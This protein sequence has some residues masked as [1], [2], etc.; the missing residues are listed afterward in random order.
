VG[1]QS[2]KTIMMIVASIVCLGLIA[3]F[4]WTEQDSGT[5]RWWHAIVLLGV[6][7]LAV[8]AK[9][10]PWIGKIEQLIL[11]YIGFDQEKEEGRGAKREYFMALVPLAFIVSAY[12]MISALKN[13]SINVVSLIL[14]LG[15]LL[16]ALNLIAVS[17]ARRAS[18]KWV[19]F[20]DYIAGWIALLGSLTFAIDLFNVTNQLMNGSHANTALEAIYLVLGLIGVFAIMLFF[21]ISVTS[22]NT[23]QKDK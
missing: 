17:F 1:T 15:I 11:R 16:Y 6:L 20:T 3:F 18:T 21:V 8:I 9:I 23:S 12:L 7:I 2:R 4:S 14:S 13:S 22:K 10:T 5:F 19:K